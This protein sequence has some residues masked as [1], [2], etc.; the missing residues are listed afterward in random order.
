MVRLILQ[1]LI[2][3]SG[4]PP[5]LARQGRWNWLKYAFEVITQD[6]LYKK[7]NEVHC[8]MTFYPWIRE[9]FNS[10]ASGVRYYLRLQWKWLQSTLREQNYF[11]SQ[12]LFFSNFDSNTRC[13]NEVEDITEKLYSR[14]GDTVS[15]KI[16]LTAYDRHWDDPPALELI[17]NIGQK[18]RP[19]WG[20]NPR[21]LD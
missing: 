21:P 11:Q 8:Q 15:Q 20:S 9:V 6:L 19:T 10:H 5:I 17:W 16:D 4:M 3:P 13:K 2:F 12:E 7:I 14:F 1:K 18:A